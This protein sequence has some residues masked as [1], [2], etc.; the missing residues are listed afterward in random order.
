MEDSFSWTG[1]S[2]RKKSSVLLVQSFL[3]SEIAISRLEYLVA[4]SI[5][6][7]TFHT[8]KLGCEELSVET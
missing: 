8:G 1:L 5:L 2:V 4:F 6:L 3:Q 7:V